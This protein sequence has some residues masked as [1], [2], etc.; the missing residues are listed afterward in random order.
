M[1][2]YSTGTVAVTNGAVSVTGTGTAFS[3]NARVGDGFKGPDGRW[4]EVTNIASATVLSILPAYQG[5]TASGQT[6][7]IAPIQGY[8]KESAD[9]LRA[10]SDSINAVGNNARLASIGGATLATNDLLIATGATTVG[11]QATGTVGRSVIAA[12]TTAAAK[13]AIALGNVDNTSDINKPVSTA[14]ANAIAV[15]SR[16]YNGIIA[17][18]SANSSLPVDIVG[19]AVN[20]SGGAI[21]TL[22]SATSITNGSAVFIRNSGAASA[23]VNPQG[24]D[25]IT[26][27][28]GVSTL[29]LVTMEYV[30]LTVSGSSWWVTG[31]GLVTDI[32]SRITAQIQQF[33][34]G[35]TSVPVITDYNSIL[36]TGIYRDST[37]T[38]TGGPLTSGQVG[39]L[40]NTRFSGNGCSQMLTRLS[41]TLTSN[42]AWY[43]SQTGGTWSTWREFAFL[44]NPVFTGTFSVPV[45]VGQYTLTTLPSAS[46][47]NGY[48]IDVTNATGG[49]KRCRSNGTVWQILNTTTTVS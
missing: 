8:V 3:A 20:V 37:G 39:T 33:G 34:L 31:R 24:S 49:S 32:P 27:N 10:I 48:E 22:P 19:K 35:S 41:T 42:Q 7:S 45:R 12:A 36:E 30:E 4:Y 6:Y 18:Y 43:R 25:T 21:L 17:N 38:G 15:S 46:T 26:T 9:R 11:G 23:T 13:T 5:T 14:T 28:T 40:V 1:A 2:W 44:D 29:S 16:Q 47:Y